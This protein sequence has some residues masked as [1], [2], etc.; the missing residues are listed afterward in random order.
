MGAVRIGQ[1]MEY[2]ENWYVGELGE[3]IVVGISR[4]Q[5]SLGEL[6]LVVFVEGGY[7]QDNLGELQFRKYVE[8]GY[9]QE[10]WRIQDKQNIWK[11]RWDLYISQEMQ[12]KQRTYY[13]QVTDCLGWDYWYIELH[14]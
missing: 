6:A 10:N 13:D 9:N 5:E 8:D 7:N 12:T 4:R 14:Y 2:W 11:C 3:F 1:D